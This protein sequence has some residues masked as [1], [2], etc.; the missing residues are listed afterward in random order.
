[1]CN[2]KRLAYL[3]KSCSEENYTQNFLLFDLLKLLEGINLNKNTENKTDEQSPVQQKSAPHA[4]QPQTH[5]VMAD[6]LE[7]HERIASKVKSGK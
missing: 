7:R 3:K 6:V 1:L 2:K 5:N 4:E